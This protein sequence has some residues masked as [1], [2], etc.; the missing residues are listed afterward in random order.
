MISPR[1]GSETAH[2]TLYAVIAVAASGAVV[3]QAPSDTRYGLVALVAF[4]FCVADLTPLTLPRGGA[5]ALSGGVATVALS[6]LQ[7]IIGAGALVVGVCAAGAVRDDP[8]SPGDLLLDVSRRLTA[9]SAAYWVLRLGGQFAGLFGG[10][11]SYVGL[12]AL[13]AG[14]V[15]MVFDV[16]GFALLD[17]LR[18]NR[19]MIRST[20]SLFSLI[21][22]IYLSQVFVGAAATIV[23]SSLQ[24]VGFIILFVLMLLLQSSFALLLRVR[25]AYYRTLSAVARLAE[26]EAGGSP[27]H[28]ERVAEI[29]TAIA[30]IRHMGGQDAK[31]LSYAALL[32]N[33]GDTHGGTRECMAS[34]SL[35][36]LFDD[37]PY[38]SG[39]GAVVSSSLMPFSATAHG[40]VRSRVLGGILR[41]ACAYDA[42]LQNHPRSHVMTAL[43]SE[44]YDPDSVKALEVAIAR[45]EV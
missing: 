40:D 32:H 24:V 7:P 37:I 38:L 34:N 18:A 9:L 44:N 16:L 22:G 15:Y 12:A 14:C 3:H 35:S 33:V 31:L 21:G 30:R 10:I 39:V 26:C 2:R 5:I 13:L 43:T 19:S 25:A 8:A 4:A 20:T 29:A 27:G 42:L 17:S 36:E 23:Y 28:S 6:M 11:P 45:Q 1:I 41:L